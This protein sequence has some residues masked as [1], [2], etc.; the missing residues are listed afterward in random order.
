MASWQARDCGFLSSA[1]Q[2]MQATNQHKKLDPEPTRSPVHSPGPNMRTSIREP[3]RKETNPIKD[4]ASAGGSTRGVGAWGPLSAQKWLRL[5]T[6][7][8]TAFHKTQTSVT[9]AVS[10]GKSMLP[11]AGNCSWPQR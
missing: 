6:L 1:N 4:S 10:P 3:S 11:D 7:R 5:L 2:G 9:R 8:G